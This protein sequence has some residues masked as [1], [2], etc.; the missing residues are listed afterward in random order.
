VKTSRKIRLD[1]L[2]AQPMAVGL[3]LLA[4]IL[5]HLLRRD[6]SIDPQ[7]VRTITVAKF[8]GMGSIVQAAPLLRALKRS[9]PGARLVFVTS[10]ANRSLLEH[11]ADVDEALFV[12]D[13][14][15]LAVV[16]SSLRTVLALAR[17]RTDLYFDLEIYSAYASLVALTSLARLR[18]GFYRTS[19]RFKVGIYTHLLYFNTQRPVRDLY[20]QLGRAAGVPEDA[21]LALSPLHLSDAARQGFQEKWQRLVGPPAAEPQVVINPNASDLLMERRWPAGHVR[22]TIEVLVARGHDVVLT[23]AQDERPYVEE[24]IAGLSGAARERVTD[25]SG[26]L[27]L[28]ELLALLEGAACVITNDSGPMHMAL[29]F[30]RPTVCLFGPCDPAHYGTSKSNVA[31]LYK[32]VLCSPC[33]HHTDEPPCGGDNVCMKRIA[34]AEVIAACEKLLSSG[35]SE[36]HGGDPGRSGSPETRLDS[37]GGALGLAVRDSVLVDLRPCE[38][39][40]ETRFRFRFRRDELRLIRCS[41]CGLERIDPLPEGAAAVS[42][43]RGYYAAWGLDEAPD[44]ARAVKRATFERHL[45]RLAG[46]LEPGAR[47]LDCGAATGFFME[48]AAEGGLEPYGVEISDFGADQIASRFGDNRV[49]RGEVEKASFPHL[50]DGTFQAVWMLD[51]L[52]HVRDPRAALARVHQLLAPGG[53]LFATTPDTGSLSRRLMGNRW[54]HYKPEHLFYFSRSNLQRLLVETGFEVVATGRTHKMLTLRYVRHQFTSYPHPLLTPLSRVLGRL[55]PRA[56]LDR[57]FPVA[58]GEMEIQARR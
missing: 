30:D 32:G 19:A 17:R 14:S 49:F 27:S 20:M 25:T 34:P 51:V 43:D 48:V 55:A 38:S 6:H 33:V 39:C 15:P 3:N 57:P 11:L 58:T 1:R 29:A 4:R 28:A 16:V 22:E 56:L 9:F 13:R 37:S 26:R 40:G 7:H 35:E 50:G 36:D 2:V 46:G 10:A 42:Y 12:D 18:F 45:G 5:G 41:M 44:L 24:L 23:G 21:D 31:I 52:E 47:V 53:V 8:V 54:T